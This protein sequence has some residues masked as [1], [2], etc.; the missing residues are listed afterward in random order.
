MRSQP[1]FNARFAGIML[2]LGSLAV[3]APVAAQEF[4]A[5]VVQTP[6]KGNE[7]TRVS[8]GKTKV[9]LQE[10]ENGRPQGGA[11]FDLTTNSMVIIDDDDRSYMGGGNDPVLNLMVAATMEGLGA[12]PIWRFFRPTDSSDP[13]TEWNAIATKIAR[14]DTTQPPPHFTCKGLGSDNVDGRSANKWSVTATGDGKTETGLV[15]I[16]SRLHVV[17]RSQD[18]TGEMHLVNVKEGPQPDAV[19]AIPSNY[20]Q[21]NMTDALAR[22]QNGQKGGSLLSDAL[23]KAAK[24]VGKGAADETADAAKQKAKNDLKKKLKGIIHVP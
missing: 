7:S 15:W 8:V 23:A 17:S 22:L 20:R 16:D 4:S 12:P 10:L 11:I 6:A 13:C 19:F 3:A 14:R 5:D 24:E 1:Q 2:A 21:L 18:K 9:R